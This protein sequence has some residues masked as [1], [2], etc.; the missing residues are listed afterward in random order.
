MCIYLKI[1][2]KFYN[3][4]ENGFKSILSLMKDE[5]RPPCFIKSLNTI[6]VLPY[7]FHFRSVLALQDTDLLLGDSD[8]WYH[9]SFTN[10]KAVLGYNSPTKKWNDFRLSDAYV[11]LFL[12][13]SLLFPYL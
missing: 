13:K 7:P 5:R 12:S 3:Q 6:P 2:K 11:S 8:N 4:L 10:R 1:K 9:S